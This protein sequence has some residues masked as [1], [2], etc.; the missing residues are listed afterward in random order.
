MGIGAVSDKTLFVRGEPVL[1]TTCGHLQRADWLTA[2]IHP[3]VLDMLPLEARIKHQHSIVRDGK[4][5]VIGV[6]KII[7]NLV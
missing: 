1:E 4:G 7:P 5:E 2:T 3:A 6:N